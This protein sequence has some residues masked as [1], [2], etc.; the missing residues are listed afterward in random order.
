MSTPRHDR[1]AITRA[2]AE[3]LVIARGGGFCVGHSTGREDGFA[4]RDAAIDFATEHVV[5]AAAP[6]A[7]YELVRDTP[8]AGT[9]V[10]LF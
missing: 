2:E 4:T 9:A 10:A 3:R 8:P 1:R 5:F 6:R 7:A